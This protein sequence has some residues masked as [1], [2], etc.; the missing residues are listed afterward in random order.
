MSDLLEALYRA[1]TIMESAPA[2]PFYGRMSILPM[3]QAI[4]FEVEGR[5]F[6]AA[7]P[8]MWERIDE[9]T[10]STT[11]DGCLRPIFGIPVHDL[12][13][14]EGKRAEFAAAWGR[15]AS[16]SSA[17][18][19]IATETPSQRRTRKHLDPQDSAG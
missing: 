7:H 15:A 17:I 1:R 16:E 5:Q 12:D 3:D 8:N 19:A 10:R 14:D 13:R 2:E 6:V 18:V 11:L 4:T 9:A